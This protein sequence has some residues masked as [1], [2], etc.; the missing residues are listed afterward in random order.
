METKMG[1]SFLGMTKSLVNNS[2]TDELYSSEDLTR[3]N[4]YAI[5]A[6]CFLSK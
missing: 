2:K 5:I 4:S 6:Q 3:E 1:K